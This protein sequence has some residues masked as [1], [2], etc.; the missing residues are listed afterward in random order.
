MYVRVD[1]GNIER[2]ILRRHAAGSKAEAS[3]FAPRYS[4]KAG[5]LMLLADALDGAEIGRELRVDRSG[6][7]YTT[8]RQPG[9]GRCCGQETA[10]FTVVTRM[11]LNRRTQEWWHELVT[12]FPDQ[13][14]Q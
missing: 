1:D 5:L 10:T 3:K 11:K 14:W 7:L 13:S 6:N 4:S 9:V 8:C 12:A 2:H